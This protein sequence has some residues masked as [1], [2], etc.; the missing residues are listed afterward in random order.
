MWGLGKFSS[1][2]LAA[3]SSQ[4]SSYAP[5]SMKQIRGDLRDLYSILG[6]K[7]A[8]Y[9]QLSPTMRISH[10]TPPP[11]PR[12]DGEQE[13]DW[14]DVLNADA[15]IMNENDDGTNIFSA[16]A[17]KH[18]SK[19][20]IALYLPGLDGFGVSAAIWQFNDLARTFD[21][22]RLSISIDDRSSFSEVVKSV[23]SFIKEISEETKRPVYLIGESFGGLLAPAVVLNVQNRA[24]RS[25]MDN[26][27]K[28]LVMVN[29]ATSFDQ[30]SWDVLAPVLSTLGFQ[31][32]N[33]PTPFNLPSPYAVIGGLTLSSL[34]PSKQ[35]QK[36]LIDTILGILRST[37]ASGAVGLVQEMLNSFQQTE[38][39][40]P[41]GLLEHR[42]KNWM[43][44]GS[45]ILAGE[46]R[47]GQIDM[48]T[49]VVVGS[50]DKLI[51]SKL[52]ANRLEK[53]LPNC[54]KLV[55]RGAGHLVLDENV[56][57]TE[58]IVYSDIDPLKRKEEK[59]FDPV[60][61]W[62]LPPKDVIDDILERS[63]K[64]L[65]TA[66]SPIFMSTDKAGTRTMG[67]GNL[68]KDESPLLFVSNH[69]LLGLDLNLL[70]AKLLDNDIVV[71]G[72]GHPILF[73]GGTQSDELGGRT[74]GLQPNASGTGPNMSNYRQFGAVKVT[75]RNYYRILQSGQNAL[76]FPGGVR[77]VFHG[78][79]EAYKLFW[80]EKVDFVRTAAKFN[81]TIIPIS[82]VGM[83]D[84]LN[85]VLDRS[86]IMNLP[87][88]GE[89][90][91]SFAA[92][93]TSARFDTS[94]ADEVFLAPIVAPGLPSRNYFIFG[95]PLSTNEV[96]HTD[97]ASCEQA[98]HQVKAEMN[99]GFHDILTAREKDVYR[100]APQRLAYERLT[101][102]KAP[103][104]DIAEVNRVR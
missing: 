39:T 41:P 34:V 27:I 17:K 86:E 73:Q 99:R 2:L 18:G 42:I 5:N 63:V 97:K 7:A 79:N 33:R 93:I 9:K 61:D 32:Q 49:L 101:G 66:F 89:R 62:K 15:D 55:V 96:D 44:V 35:Q 20:P 80:P 100:Q 48:P 85:I 38:E 53:I 28:G 3:S 70:V 45:T 19:K 29:P 72:L 36:Q 43:I 11:P 78:R 25:G 46:Q 14:R 87:L 52:E 30:S 71:R 21:L 10:V 37:D 88:I 6:E 83:A 26:P 47:L 81:A 92:N 77:E 67:L 58:A 12:R 50:D 23:S 16:V 76:L 84:S 51:E 22:W 74:P 94:D 24:K 102:Q 104:F 91:M 57:L 60:L 103:T 31:S 59:Q 64:P 69:Q 65:E 54:T 56:N 1:A 13:V 8:V 40:L 4:S 75:P 98:Y 68:P 95:K 82:A 90:A